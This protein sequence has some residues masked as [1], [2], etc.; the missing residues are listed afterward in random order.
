MKTLTVVTGNAHKA[1]EVAAFFGGEV[2]VRH[3]SLDIPEIQ[4]E[5]LTEIARA[6]AA[7]AY[8][9]LNEPLI[10][11]D[12]AFYIDALNGFPGPYAAYVLTSIGNAGILKLMEGIADRS[13]RFVTAIGYADAIG[14]RI[15]TGTIHGRIIAK[16]RGTNG[17]GYDPIFET[18]NG[19]T[20]AEL[21]L[22][23]KS[24]VSHRARALAAFREGIFRTHE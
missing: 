5:D 7:Y 10:V 16:T 20:L 12:T 8:G 11:D 1:E 21:P 14:V 2:N 9:K 4:S 19:L 13:A 18:E 22:T 24:V 17:F 6:K 3:V 23:E 15:F